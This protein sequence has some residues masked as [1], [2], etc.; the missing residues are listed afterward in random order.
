MRYLKIFCLLFLAALLTQPVFAGRQNRDITRQ[1]LNNFDNFLDTHPAIAKDL[2]SNPAL[3]KDSAYLSAHPELKE[4]LNN[5]PGVREEIRENPNGFMKRERNF[6]KAGKDISPAEV[7]TFDDFLDKHPAVNKEL[8]KN[9]AL[10]NDPNFVAKHPELKE[11][12]SSHPAIRQD[13]A[14]HPRIFMH[15]EKKFDKTE[16]REEQREERRERNQFAEPHGK[17]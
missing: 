12:L 4:F 6:E 15:D 5:H 16:R 13:L 3:V 1:E 10:V 8:R 14:Q 9:P 7:K 2:R 17:H 11:F